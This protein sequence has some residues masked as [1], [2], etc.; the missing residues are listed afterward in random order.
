MMCWRVFNDSPTSCMMI[1]NI[2][3]K[4]RRTLEVWSFVCRS[5]GLF[6]CEQS[7]ARSNINVCLHAFQYFSASPCLAKFQKAAYAATAKWLYCPVAH[8]ISTSTESIPHY[9]V[10]SNTLHLSYFRAQPW[11]FEWLPQESSS[12]VEPKNQ[13]SHPRNHHAI[14][15]FAYCI[16]LCTDETYALWVN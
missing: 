15:W 16:M 12:Y 11:A 7:G 4:T 3:S 6:L 5:F 1:K 14:R 13:N 8:V 9:L 2:D 10:K